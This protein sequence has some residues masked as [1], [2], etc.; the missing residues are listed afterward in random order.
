MD[1][2]KKDDMFDFFGITKPLFV[3]YSLPGDDLQRFVDR[4]T[5]LKYFSA[6]IRN[7][8]RCAVLGDA[9][10][11]K[12]AFL[13]KLLDITKDSIYG[14]YLQ[15]SF[16]EE[17]KK[18]RLHFLR[19]ILRSIL[20]MIIKHDKLLE[21]FNHE[22]IDFEIKRLEYSVVIEDYVKKQE[23]HGGEV[24]GG[25]KG[26]F[27]S[28]LIPAEFTARLKVNREQETGKTERKD[29]PVH[30]EDTL[31]ASI[32]K[33]LEKID[34]PIVLFI[35]ELDKTGRYPLESPVWD[36][37]VIRILELSRDLMLTDKL[38]LVFALQNELFEKLSLAVSEGR[39]LSILGL[40][41]AFK[42]IG[43][44]NLEFA[45]EAVNASL[46]Y[47]G[48]KRTMGDLFETGVIETVLLKVAGNPRWFMW[49]LIELAKET[50]AK[51]QPK[52]SLALLKDFMFEIDP[53]MTPEKWHELTAKIPELK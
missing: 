36:K 43:G 5:L 25:I 53:K 9:G 33:L 4:E 17:S 47:A 19:R 46:K 38:I 1:T 50:H 18:S 49:F 48:Y 29:F 16:P 15:F 8:Q 26:N 11:G 22:E 3:M 44:F 23:S 41:N 14:D 12:S 30:N 21:H 7:G 32:G 34:Q 31:F 51:N 37:E 40:I 27:L 20:Y 24:E 35:D 2:N 10:S 13:L 39:D 45:R 6:S 28:F 52:I 42:K